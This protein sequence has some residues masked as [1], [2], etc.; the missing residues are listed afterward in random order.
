MT[1]TYSTYTHTLAP[2]LVLT[3]E[4][5]SRGYWEGWNYYEDEFILESAKLAVFD[6]EP[7]DLLEG[8]PRG[9]DAYCWLEEAHPDKF[10][11][12]DTAMEKGARKDVAPDAREAA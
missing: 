9:R 12:V 3:V 7:V 2:G 4:G 6:G 5:E 11:L 10:L 8:L 1:R